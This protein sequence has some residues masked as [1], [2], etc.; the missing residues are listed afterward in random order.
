[1]DLFYYYIHQYP[2]LS[3]AQTGLTIW[4]A[5]DCY[6][7]GAEWFWF[8]IILFFQP[9]G[10]WVYF[11]AVK[12]GDLR[13]SGGSGPGWLGSLFQRKTPIE[14][15]RY[16]AEHVP[17]LT[18]QLA[19]AERLIEL[20]EYEEAITFLDLAMAREPDHCRINY[21]HA[22]CQVELGAPLK[23]LPFL[24][25]VIARDAY[26]SDYSAWRLLV[27]ARVE[28]NDMEG[29]LETCSELAR[30]APTLQHRCMLAERLAALDRNEE[31]RK[32]LIRALDEQRYAPAT[33]K[34]LNR[35]WASEA[36][37]LI[38][39]LAAPSNK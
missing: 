18:N 19:L 16:K 39:R 7:R 22:V 17:T 10:A 25:K 27:R 31:G 36:K 8:W 9:I 23:A 20:E 2:I 35:K 6:Q 34:R 15:L 24:D 11:L 26:W 1:M 29:A 30:I 32:L 12:L 5:I 37:R 21:C 14:E 33:A 38:K 3:L 4:M 28:L 13:G